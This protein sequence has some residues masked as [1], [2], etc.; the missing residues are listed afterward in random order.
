MTG[1]SGTG[2]T[3][4]SVTGMT[5]AIVTGMTSADRHGHDGYRGLSFSAAEFMQ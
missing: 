3:G 5:S 4:A 1:A 2:M